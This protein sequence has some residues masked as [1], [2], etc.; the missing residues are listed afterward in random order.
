MKNN[1]ECKMCLIREMDQAGIDIEKYKSAIKMEDRVT[2]NVYEE[3]LSVCKQC[4]KLNAGTCFSCGCY[5]EL[6]ALGKTN[7]CPDKKW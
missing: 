5:V 6:R 4:Q 2:E 1:N 3:R 7:H